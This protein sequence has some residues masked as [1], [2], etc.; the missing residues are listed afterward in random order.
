MKLHFLNKSR[1]AQQLIEFL[2]I[3][4]FMVIVFGILTEYAYGLNTNLTLTQG[5]KTVTSSIYSQIKP[6]MTSAQIRTL[7]D[8]DLKAYLEANH[9]PLREE[10]TY[11]VGYMVQGQNIIF[12]ASYRYVPAFTL[13]MFYFKIL[14]DSLTF[15]ATSVVPR[16]F[17][18]ANDY[19][20][21]DSVKLDKIW[22]SGANF[23][24]LDSFNASKK[25]IMTT[26]VGANPT[27]TTKQ[28]FL[29]PITTPLA[30]NKTYLMIPFNFTGSAIDN[31][32]VN[33]ADGN[34][35]SCD[36]SL[37]DGTST[38]CD[39]ANVK[40]L[41]YLTTNNF[42]S[43]FFVHDVAVPAKYSDLPSAWITGSGALSGNSVD[44]ILKRSLALIGTSGVSDGN[45]DNIDV[46]SYNPE[47]SI[48][49]SYEVK[50]F[51]SVVF[52]H[53]PGS[54]DLSKIV[55]GQ[56]PPSCDYVLSGG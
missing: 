46:S 6:G 32:V 30:N 55:D 23:S 16:A 44:G 31:R 49:N 15:F 22:S 14:P 56:S 2:L 7:V 20:N 17:L 36:G 38:K 24:S 37:H 54:D 11:S 35:Y 21:V 18:S 52:I 4:P 43:V 29:L 40:F 34:L 12:M 33:L 48:G 9:V 10:N 42:Y 50:T 53:N 41:S 27:T 3:A 45:F 1:K 47:V 25:G 39:N 19:P 28:M 13:P 51:G 8:T 26:S 5:L